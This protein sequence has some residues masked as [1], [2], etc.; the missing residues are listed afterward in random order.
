MFRRAALLLTAIALVAAGLGGATAAQAEPAQRAATS[1]TEFKLSQ[2]VFAGKGRSSSSTV[3]NGGSLVLL[4]SYDVRWWG[5]RAKPRLSLQRKIG[6]G[7]WK[8][9][10]ATVSMGK[11][12]LSARTPKYSTA[13]TKRTVAYRF[14][15]KAYTTS[16]ARVRTT[17]RSHVVR[18]TY[19]NQR[20]YT[21]LAK[22]VWDFAKPYC[23]N[24]AVHVAGLS[25]G[26]GDYGTGALLIRVVSSVQSYPAIDVRALALH[27]C[28]HERQW[29]N[30][31]GTV[32][33][34]RTMT[35]AAA[36]YFSDWTKPADV[37][38]PYP[39]T[40]PAASISPIEHAADCGAQ[41]LNPGG[42]LG[43][44]GYC[45]PK[46]LSEGKRLLLGK[47]Y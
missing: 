17:S 18:I 19:E 3:G 6:S 1:V 25:T 10:S 38:T 39:Y 2:L 30:Y 28:S 29:L 8:T 27:E 11:D 34:N 7:A 12:G 35:K 23:P 26:A 32:A 47:R 13:G 22:S 44:G 45:T 41:A 21:G 14:V 16:R 20:K 5:T 36:R 9:T 37:T 24:T 33:G 43:Y 42:Y 31:G 4:G 46:Q 40:E 15:S